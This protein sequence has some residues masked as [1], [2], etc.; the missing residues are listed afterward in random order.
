MPDIRHRVGITAPADQV[1]DA[2]A[3]RDGLTGWW[4]TD[5]SGGTRPGD[6]LEF[7]FGGPDAAARMEV[8]EVVDPSLVRW[9]CVDGPDDWRNTTLSFE[10]EPDGDQT[11]VL[12]TH[13]DWR[14]P[15]PFLHHCSTKWAQFLL[16]MKSGLEGGEATPWPTDE[17]IDS[18]G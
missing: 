7:R 9:R 12:F 8:L 2:V 17:P 3:T 5:V 1:F 14:E 13:A 11:A 18:W 6:E 10:I 16:G 4:T 15:S